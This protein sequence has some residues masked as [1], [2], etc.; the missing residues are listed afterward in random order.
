MQLFNKQQF[1][2]N[3]LCKETRPNNCNNI[4]QSRCSLR[5]HVLAC[6]A[7]VTKLRPAH[8]FLCVPDLLRPARCATLYLFRRELKYTFRTW[9]GRARGGEGE[10]KC[11][12]RRTCGRKTGRV[13]SAGG[14]RCPP[15]ILARLLGWDVNA[16]WMLCFSCSSIAKS[17]DNDNTWSIRE[18]CPQ[19]TYS[20]SVC[21][22]NKFS[23]EGGNMIHLESPKCP[24]RKHPSSY[25]AVVQH[26]VNTWETHGICKNGCLSLLIGTLM[27]WPW[28]G[29]AIPQQAT[30]FE[31]YASALELNLCNR[32]LPNKV[33]ECLA[34]NTSHGLAM[35]GAW[36]IL[37]LVVFTLVVR[38][39]SAIVSKAWTN[40]EKGLACT[41]QGSIPSQVQ[42]V[43]NINISF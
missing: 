5:R 31:N 9:D 7:P 13:L 16:T 8:M 1:T 19:T 21:E 6:A 36:T 37:A 28:L 10:S 3:P 22:Q 30:I 11:A 27:N 39:M 2:R 41:A 35:I 29:K 18:P 25:D 26:T 20:T 12:G 17:S 34:R 4:S 42:N 14:S 43:W 40:R 32:T 23:G 33:Y 15:P 38:L 24:F